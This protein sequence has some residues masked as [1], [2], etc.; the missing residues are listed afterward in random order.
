MDP[1][2]PWQRLALP[3]LLCFVLSLLP[4]SIVLNGLDQV[5]AECVENPIPTGEEEEQKH[6]RPLGSL[7]QAHTAHGSLLV[8]LARAADDRL[9]PSPHGEVLLRPPKRF[10]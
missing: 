9:L 2:I 5:A 6:A 7:H 4:S 10:L 1:I 8:D 3:L